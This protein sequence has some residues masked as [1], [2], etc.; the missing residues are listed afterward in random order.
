MVHFRIKSTSE[1]YYFW[2]KRFLWLLPPQ[3]SG[4]GEWTLNILIKDALT[5]KISAKTNANIK[6]DIFLD[7][8][9][10]VYVS[11]SI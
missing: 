10:M 2:T 8:D 11:L 5:A 9:T 7:G 1:L 3:S 4:W 6:I